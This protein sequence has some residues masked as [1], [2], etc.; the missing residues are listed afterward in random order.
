MTVAQRVYPGEAAG[1]GTPGVLVLTHADRIDVG[2]MRTTPA[3]TRP[4]RLVLDAASRVFPMWDYDLIL[5]GLIA[6][7]ISGRPMSG[8][9]A[10]LLVDVL[11]SIGWTPSARQLA[12]AMPYL[13]DRLVMRDMRSLIGN[14]G[15]RCLK[16]RLQGRQLKE[17]ENA[18]TLVELDGHLWRIDQSDGV[19][20]GLVRPA[21][22]GQEDQR[23]QIWPFRSYDILFCAQSDPVVERDVL[24]K[25][26]GFSADLFASFSAEGRLLVVLTLLTGALTV[27]FSLAVMFLFNLVVSGQ[28][29]S[30]IL[31]VLVG[32]SAMFLVDYGFR[33]IR[34]RTLGQIASKTEH[35]LGTALFD[36]L[37]RLPR[38]MIDQAPISEQTMRLRELEGV[39]DLFASPFASVLLETPVTLIL[40]GVIAA[41]SVELALLLI[42]A[43]LF[44]LALGLCVLPAVVR[45]TADLSAARRVL[46]QVQVEAIEKGD[47]LSRNGLA[48]PWKEKAH[49]VASVAVRS[50]F[51]L[52]R[53]TAVLETISYLCV[54]VSVASIMFI[55]ALQVT[56]GSLSGGALIAV[57]MLTW[58]ALAPVQQGLLLMPKVKDLLRLFRQIDTMMRFPSQEVIPDIGK[59]NTEPQLLR[60]SNI[61]L[62][63]ASSKLPAFAGVSLNVPPGMLVS[64]SGASGSGKS[65]LLGVL[66]GQI[67]PQAGSVWLG[68][69]CLTEL[70]SSLLGRRIVFVPPR[71]PLIYGTLA[72]NL[73]FADPLANDS[74]ITNVLREVGLGDL[75]EN[76]PEGI[77]DRIDPVSNKALLSG[78]V[79]MAVAVAQGLL[80]SPAVLMIDE[81]AEDIEPGI[82]AAVFAAVHR[83]RGRMTTLLVTHRPSIIRRSDG[84]IEVVNRN[85]VFHNFAER[86][87]VAV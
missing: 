72:Q 4:G 9:D 36:K 6:G 2:R 63:S 7:K 58:R 21:A 84:L 34:S 33:F 80:M 11:R 42:G 52:A 23:R 83:R 26:Q 86:R 19:A 64:V 68:S 82:E 70:P 14:L 53:A 20:H 75:I 41:F 40:I 27:L 1:A 47:L 3:R 57:T 66:A 31:A 22:H 24:S 48:W 8:Q 73:R 13:I 54:P 55:G 43:L 81:A 87:N 15:F 62:R 56:S 61:V 16:R 59:P 39:R 60:A 67:P 5:D 85:V 65:A 46:L 10:H 35:K 17:Y 18:V 44:F 49:R 45:R 76:L 78:G 29:P 38:K 69:S 79:R 37:M 77:H 25:H 12:G 28:Q 51:R 71:T 30:V 32:V 74:A 50:R